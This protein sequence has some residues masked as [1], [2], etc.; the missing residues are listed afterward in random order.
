MATTTYSTCCGVTSTDTDPDPNCRRNR[1][2]PWDWTKR[3][4][5]ICCGD[6][7]CFYAYT[8]SPFGKQFLIHPKLNDSTELMIVWD[9]LK[10]NFKD[11]DIVP[12]PEQA[13][14]AVAAYVKW[15]VLLEVDKRVDLAREQYAIYAQKRLA[16]YR[17]EQEAMDVDGRDEEYGSSGTPIDPLDGFGAQ[18]IPFLRN[19]TQL[20]GVEGD[21]ISL[22]AIP[23]TAI[24]A[25]YAVEVMIGGVVA[26]WVLIAS[27]VA[28]DPLN[29]FL[30]PLDFNATTNGKVWIKL[31]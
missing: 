13:A 5:L 11:V 25:P 19:V 3:H 12:F 21:L 9:G 30:R 27:V 31:T 23:T 10:M 4:E 17:E 18:D 7:L 1:L 15:R 20:S 28:D 24:T 29:G 8:I 26:R 2:Q 6:D 14:E 16:L 22:N